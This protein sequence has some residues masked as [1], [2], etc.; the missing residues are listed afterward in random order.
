MRHFGFVEM[1][2]KRPREDY[3][4]KVQEIFGVDMSAY[5]EEI[6]IKRTPFGKKLFEARE[7]KGLTQQAVADMFG[8]H[9][10]TYQRWETN[11]E[12]PAKHDIEMRKFLN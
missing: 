7:K 11:K 12:V 10:G 3:I 5:L 1:R 8:V 2:T 9:R 4:R 6:E